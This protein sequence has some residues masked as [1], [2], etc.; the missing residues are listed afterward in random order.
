MLAIKGFCVENNLLLICHFFA[1][2]S[3]Q[4]YS[5]WAFRIFCCDIKSSS[6]QEP[7]A[8]TFPRSF[9][10]N[11]SEQ[12]CAFRLPLFASVWAQPYIQR[13]LLRRWRFGTSSWIFYRKGCYCC[14]AT[15][16]SPHCCTIGSRRNLC[17]SR[18]LSGTWL[19]IAED[20][21]I[22]TA[23]HIKLQRTC[24][25][26]SFFERIESK[27]FCLAAAFLKG[28]EHVFH[29]Q[30]QGHSYKPHQPLK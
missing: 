26:Q 28:C 5:W 11:S 29:L 7:Y 24:H 23:S 16:H 15:T 20:S 27:E 2:L 17:W 4:E 18:Q 25:I 10:S 14:V 21:R 30:S 22:E 12:L 1:P 8:N 3:T 6:F 13:I 9:F 19:G